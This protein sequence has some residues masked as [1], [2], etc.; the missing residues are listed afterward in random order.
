[1]VGHSE[2]GFC[3]K[4]TAHGNRQQRWGGAGV[5]SGKH[6]R[7]GGTATTATGDSRRSTGNGG[8]QF[9]GASRALFFFG[10]AAKG[11]CRRWRAVALHRTVSRASANFASTG[12]GAS[13]ARPQPSHGGSHLRTAQEGRRGPAQKLPPASGQRRGK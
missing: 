10:K 12:A 13:P 9:A 4:P 3:T 2:D 1:M 6:R 7:L 11:C 5:R 8:N